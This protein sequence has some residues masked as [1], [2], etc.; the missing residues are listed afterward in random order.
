MNNLLERVNL[1]ESFF[2]IQDWQIPLIPK[3][4]SFMLDSGAFSFMQN[5]KLKQDFNSYTDRYIDFI[6]DNKID[7]FFELDIDSVVG[8]DNVIKLRKQIESKTNKQ[9]IPVWH[10]SRGKEN[11]IDMCKEYNYVAIGGLVSNE[12]KSNEYH[13]LNTL[14]KIAHDNG[15]KIHGLGFTKSNLSQYLFDSVDSTAWIYG[16]RGGFLY[17]F[18]GRE[19]IKI[20]KPEGTRLKSKDVAIHNFWE[21]VKYG[22]YLENISLYCAGTGSR[23]FIFNSVGGGVKL[24][25]A[26][27]KSERRIFI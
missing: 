17:K 19:I 6:N 22:E 13:F 2:Y 21:W 20:Q 25:I 24:H 10:K 9:V 1:L 23:E 26:A 5:K 4:K 12:I 8:Y 7:L 27:T 15:A 18:N 11:F 3:V 14:C 16:N